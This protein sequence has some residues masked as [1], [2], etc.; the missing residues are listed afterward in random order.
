MLFGNYSDTEDDASA[1]AYR[2]RP[3]ATA[4]DDIAGDVWIDLFV[5]NSDV[6]LGSNG[7]RRLIH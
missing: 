3:G 5:D 6:S 2:P 4:A 1:Y 7:F